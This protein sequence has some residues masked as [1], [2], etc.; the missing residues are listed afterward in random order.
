MPRGIV[1]RNAV[2][3][4]CRL[5][6]VLTVPSEVL[7]RLPAAVMPRGWSWRRVPTTRWRGSRSGGC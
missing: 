5:L 7:V 2:D 4:N 6:V 1:T 3:F